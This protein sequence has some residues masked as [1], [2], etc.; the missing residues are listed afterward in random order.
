MRR[1]L[2]TSLVGAAA[3]A[4]FTVTGNVSA[5]ALDWQEAQKLLASDGAHSDYF[6][7][8]VALS[9][10]V[11]LVGAPGDARSVYVY[12]FDGAQWVEEQ[13]LVASDAAEG[14]RFGTSVALSGAVAL[15]G[16]PGAGVSGSA[17]VYRFDGVQWVEEQKLVASDG[18]AGDAFGGSVALS[19]AVA[20]VGARQ[21]GTPP[22]PQFR[23]PGRGSAYVYR[24]D[25]AQWVEEQKLVASDGAQGDEL[26]ASV[27]VSGDVALVGAPQPGWLPNDIR[28]GAG[29]AYVY[30]FDGGH[31]IEEQKLVASD[32]AQGDELGASVAVS[33]DVALVG[34]PQP[35]WLPNDIRPGPGSAY[36]YRFDGGHWIEEQKL[37]AR[38]WI[39]GYQFGSSVALSGDVAL[40]GRPEP[41][42]QIPWEGTT[43]A[44]PGSAYVY[45]FDGVQWVEE[46]TLVASDGVKDDRFGR[47]VAL[48]GAVALVG[49]PGD[50]II[51]GYPVSSAYV[52]RFDGAQ[53]VEQQKLVAG[54][55]VTSDRFGASVALSSGVA[56]IGAPLDGDSGD[57]S[58]STYLYERS[59]TVNLKV[60]GIDAPYPFSY[61]TTPGPVRLTL[62]MTPGRRPLGHYYFWWVGGTYYWI[63][64]QGMSTTPAPLATF[65]PVELTEVPL[66]DCHLPPGVWVFGWLM[67][68]RSV[69]WDFIVVHVTP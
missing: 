44:G 53:W 26:G 23:S 13:K 2:K 32:G 45:R 7:T 5:T 49:A 58:G 14:D 59:A 62:D 69:S 57:A 29:S 66:Y 31:W 34:A 17:Y 19:G 30:R 28:P 36:V 64:P 52:Y 55:G 42:V 50:D 10:D 15:V 48:S 67:L 11:A 33:G 8:S 35:G 27:A 25:G 39:I 65:K 16:A 37:V 21:P 6:G 46:Q 54:N 40:V 61:V 43:P 38:H 12:R 41:A 24:F 68:D 4:L 3:A 1:I 63:T 9:G 56:L 51:S 20:L 47:E 22:P 18:A 60:N